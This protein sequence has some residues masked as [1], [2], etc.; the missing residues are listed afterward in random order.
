M[1]KQNL[2]LHTTSGAAN[3]NVSNHKSQPTVN[4][5]DSKS[6]QIV[7]IA[8]INLLNHLR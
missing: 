8:K 7:S 2:M 1:R 3:I 6:R 4:Y 5:E